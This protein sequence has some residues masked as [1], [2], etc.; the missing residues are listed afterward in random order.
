MTDLPLPL[1]RF[2]GVMAHSEIEF[3]AADGAE[4]RGPS[5]SIA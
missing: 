4:A 3:V 1:P 2:F 5:Y